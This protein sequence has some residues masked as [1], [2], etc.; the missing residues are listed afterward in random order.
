[1]ESRR[2]RLRPGLCDW[3]QAEWLWLVLLPL[4]T[5]LHPSEGCVLLSVVVPEGWYLPFPEGVSAL[6]LCCCV[7]AQRLSAAG[8]FA[9]RDAVLGNIFSQ[10]WR[11]L[12]SSPCPQTCPLAS[13]GPAFVP[14]APC[15]P[16][17][18]AG[19]WDGVLGVAATSGVLS[20]V[21]LVQRLR[22]SQR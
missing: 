17:A 15:C 11:T 9:R 6:Q 5:A 3:G 18:H 21:Y 22:D 20:A 19:P 7:P 13:S 16:S 2:S 14:G 1:M 12:T 10:T 4:Q 8:P